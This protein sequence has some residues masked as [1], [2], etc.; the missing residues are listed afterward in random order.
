M[1]ASINADQVQSE[2]HRFPETTSLP[3][4]VYRGV[5]SAEGEVAA[6]LYEQLFTRN[7]WSGGWR[8][9]IYPYHHFHANQHEVLGIARGRAS[10]RFGGQKGALVAVRAGDVVVVPAGVSHCRERGSEDLLV[11][12]AYPGGKAPDIHRGT[13]GDKPEVREKI[14]KAGLPPADPVFGRQGP[15][16]RYWSQRVSTAAHDAPK[17]D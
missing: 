7:G 4:I 6:E 16:I 8:D 5:L 12:G 9:G 14:G 10:V 15:L 11:V 3:L 1:T 13:P 2:L 17:P